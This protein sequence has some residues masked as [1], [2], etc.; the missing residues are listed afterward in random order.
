MRLS[1]DGLSP[2][3]F[4]PIGLLDDAR[5]V[6]ARGAA[7]PVAATAAVDGDATAAA[8][9]LVAP[10]TELLAGA[11]DGNGTAIAVATAGGAALDGDAVHVAPV[12]VI[13]D[14]VALC[15]VDAIVAE[16]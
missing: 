14:D 6:L 9:V 11:D 3:S 16:D 12:A 15:G 13:V 8:A 7:T 1:A 4:T 10:A 2:S 5:D